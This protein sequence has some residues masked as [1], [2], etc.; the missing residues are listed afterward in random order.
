MAEGV[1]RLPATFFVVRAH[2][3]RERDDRDG[4]REAFE[5]ALDRGLLD[6]PH[7]PTW[8]VTLTW[9]ADICAWLE[10]RPR[11]R[12]T[13]D[14]L[15]PFADVMTC[16]YGP[17]GRCR[18][19]P[20]PDASNAATRPS[21]FCA[22]AVALCERMDAQA[23]L[24][25]ARHDLGALLLSLARGPP[26]SSSRRAPPPSG[27][28]AGPGPERCL[29]SGQAVGLSRQGGRACGHPQG[30]SPGGSLPTCRSS[31]SPTSGSSRPGLPRRLLPAE[32]QGGERRA[33][34]RRRVRRRAIS[35]RFSR[36]GSGPRARPRRPARPHGLAVER[37][38]VR[39]VGGHPHGREPVVAH[40]VGGRQVAAAL[41]GRARAAV[42]R[43]LGVHR[44]AARGTRARARAG[45]PPIAADLA[46][47]A[48]PARTSIVVALPSPEAP[49]AEIPLLS[50]SSGRTPTAAAARARRRRA[51]R[52][53]ASRRRAARPCVIAGLIVTLAR[54]RSTRSLS[55][56]PCSAPRTRLH[57]VGVLERAAD[58]LADPAHALRVRAR[59]SGS[60]R[61]R[62]A[63]PRRP[64]SPGR[65][66][67]RSAVAV[68]GAAARRR[69]RARPRPSRR[70]SASAPAPNGTRRGG[71]R[72]EHAL[73][74]GERAAGRAR[75]RRRS[76]RC[77]TR[78]SCARRTPRSVSSTD[79]ASLSPSVWIASWTS[80][81]SQMSS[82]RA[83]LRPA[84]RRRPR[85]SSGPPPPARSARSTGSGRADE[86]RT[87]SAALSGY[88]SSA[89]QV[90]GEPL[91]PGC[92]PR[93]Q[94]GP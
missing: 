53:R 68:A 40:H 21:N 69:A 65:T 70:C 2:A 93:F 50:T 17:V 76:P 18:R 35:G 90:G 3:A 75:G 63:R 38:R 94:T 92:V 47:H 62:A 85:G 49:Q 9:A 8:T 67:R 74:A 11:P 87:S 13:V 78:G 1:D 39:R 64:S 45:A 30:G 72:G 44:R 16:Q 26:A 6:L 36:A 61:G 66:R 55:P 80:W 86:P 43:Q 56:G 29:T 37:D 73:A 20:R 31:A 7:G 57:R 5:R 27:R 46:L 19:P 23:F 71:R 25:M 42:G 32:D 51:G 81:R 58:D 89:A 22:T 24:A 83:D 59:A 33:G 54:W 88:A 4:A 15:A 52:P 10:D 14:L 41:D 82:A 12:R 34:A 84:R 91:R 60:R 28:H 48:R 77:G 79:S